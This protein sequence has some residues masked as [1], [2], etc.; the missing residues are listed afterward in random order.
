MAG[1]LVTP[2]NLADGRYPFV[3]AQ[4]AMPHCTGEQTDMPIFYYRDPA[5]KQSFGLVVTIRGGGD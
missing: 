4:W 3:F 2:Y 5:Y 1:C